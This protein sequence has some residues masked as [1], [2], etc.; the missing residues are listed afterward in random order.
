MNKF[1]HRNLNFMVFE[2]FDVIL[3]YLDSEIIRQLKVKP[4]LNLSIESRVE[5]FGLFTKL[6]ES[7]DDGKASFLSL[8]HI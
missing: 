5:F 3:E 1:G 6:K 2:Y 4:R 8:I 7:Y